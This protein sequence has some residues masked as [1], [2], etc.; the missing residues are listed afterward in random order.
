[1]VVLALFALENLDI[2]S[3]SSAYGVW[4][5]VLICFLSQKC[6]VFRT[7]HLDVESWLSGEFFDGQQ[8]LVVEGLGGARVAGSFTAR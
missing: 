8:L 2:I 4:R 6:G 7:V 3:T 5:R 1:M